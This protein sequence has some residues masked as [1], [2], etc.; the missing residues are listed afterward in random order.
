MAISLV[1]FVNVT[2]SD[3]MRGLVQKI[4]NASVF[5]PSLRFV[6][7]VG[8]TYNYGEQTTLGSIQFRGLNEPYKP[9]TGVINPRQEQ[10]SIF[11][12]QVNT[13]H[14]LVISN[15]DMARASAIAAKVHKAGLFY[16]LAI[17]KGDPAVDLRQFPGLNAR[18]T[19]PQLLSTG[20][21]G[22]PMT[23]DNVDQLL[24]AVVGTS[25][26]KVLVMNKFVRRL[27]K[28]LR[29]R[30]GTGTTAAEVGQGFD[31]YD[32]AKILILDEDG[33]E[34]P[35]LSLNERCK[36]TGLFAPS[37]AGQPM[38]ADVKV[39]FV[40]ATHGTYTL[41]LQTVG[42]RGGLDEHQ[43]DRR[44]RRGRRRQ[45]R[46]VRLGQL[47]PPGPGGDGRGR[48]AAG[49]RLPGVPEPPGP[50]LSD[51]RPRPT[52][53]PKGNPDESEPEP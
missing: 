42:R 52:A 11:G 27:V 20:V 48:R 49:D 19:G 39:S 35:I 26:Q 30:T 51:R 44:G 16:D 34:Q 7:C 45:A 14:Q 17:V 41:T 37:G 2:P 18:L 53:P 10:L 40:D 12:G 15:G 13:D 5:L 46:R 4:T 9:D 21:N 3:K 23:L 50:G 24:D 29:Q 33:D 28:A 8:F 32:G 43:P 31:N 25:E 1:D 22:G 36:G 38:T 6:P 47:R